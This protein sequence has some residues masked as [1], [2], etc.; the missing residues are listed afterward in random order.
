MEHLRIRLL[1]DLRVEGL[2]PAAL[3]SRKARTLIAALALARG[4]PVSVGAIVDILWPHDAPVEPEHQVA[5]LVSRLR[6][7]LGQQRLQRSAAGYA[8]VCDWLD[9]AALGDL[10]DEAERRFAAGAFAAARTAAGAAL[11]LVRGPFL[12]AESDAS[13]V[14]ADRSAVERAIARSQRIAARAALAA[15]DPLAAAELAELALARDAYDEAALRTLMLALRES[16]RQAS[17]LAAYARFAERLAEDLGADPGPE[18]SDLHAALLRGQALSDSSRPGAPRPGS[19]AGMTDSLPGRSPEVAALNA[20]FART[21]AGGAGLVVLEGEAG[22]GKTR[23]LR[24]WAAMAQGQGARLA[25]VTCDELGRALPLQPLL[26]AIE[27]LTGGGRDIPEAAGLLSPFLGRSG[28]GETATLAALTDP[29]AGQALLLGAMRASV[30]ASAAAAP[31]VIVLDDAHAADPTSLAWI[32][33]V[34]RTL[35]DAAILV[36]LGVRSGEGFRLDAGM[37]IRLGPLDRQAVAAVVGAERAEA[38]FERSAG[39]PLF[40]VELAAAPDLGEVPASIAE[41][42]ARRCERMGPAA[43]TLRAAA[44]LGPEVDLDVLVSVTGG[45]PIELLDHLEDGMRR[46][47]LEDRGGVFVFRHALIREALDAAVSTARR[48]LI[49]REASRALSPRR[50]VPPLVLAHHA[51]LG[52][53]SEEAS[54]ALVAAATSA[55]GRFDGEAAIAMLDMAITLSDGAAARVLRA[56]ARTV[57]GRY[58]LAE[59]DLAVARRL[60]AQEEADEVEAWVAHF[61]RQFDRALARADDGARRGTDPDLRSVCL[62]LGGWISLARG[63]LPGAERRLTEAVTESP[64]PGLPAVWLAWLRLNQGRPEDTVALT[65]NTLAASTASV[66]FPNAYAGMSAAMA[67]AML[68]RPDEAL[69]ILDVLD[70]DIERMGAWRW[71]PRTRNVR[72]WVLRGLGEAERANELNAEAIAGSQGAA[73]LE[74]HTHAVLDLADG[75]LQ[76]GDLGGAKELLERG[77]E[78]AAGEFS[79]SWRLRL[80]ARLLRARVMAAGGDFADAVGEAQR[81]VR[82]ASGQGAV[83]Y[84]VQATLLASSAGRRAGMAVQLAAVD[85]ALERLPRLAG[86]EA[87][88][89]TAEVADAFGSP[90]WRELAGRQ[91]GALLAYAGPHAGRLRDAISTHLG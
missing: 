41:A 61:Q 49:H 5:V 72:A 42:V 68:G 51:R 47:F 12:A 54:S 65:R 3:G 20:A 33:Q 40:A 8:A 73:M 26:E 18:T 27:A 2:D 57:L 85:Q 9:V 87:W 91:A 88:R 84:A 23:L 53:E 50:Q 70:A 37:T 14:A 38:V 60:G 75:R 44:V 39:N 90:L 64:D 30:R 48:A 78:L 79:F 63:D 55:L 4:R 17:A 11:A 35:A 77:A 62:G 67:L 81:L 82:D 10:A 28:A 76:A 46:G 89:L 80:R 31:A 15:G 43:R 58:D 24:A 52:G 25:F 45:S 13:W 6:R 7:V 83:R 59:E 66:R 56:R 71:A 19:P 1:G 22:I 29:G 36:V 21:V 69:R 34:E 74:S 16:D 32:A 86:L